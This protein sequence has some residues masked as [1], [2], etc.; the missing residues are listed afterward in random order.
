MMVLF[1]SYA[2]RGAG[3]FSL[4]RVLIDSGRMPSFLRPLAAPKT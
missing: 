3:A 4:D 1:L 2:V